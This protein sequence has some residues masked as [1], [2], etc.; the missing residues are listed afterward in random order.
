MWA[1]KFCYCGD[2]YGLLV[3]A[4]CLLAPFF[5]CKIALSVNKTTLFRFIPRRCRFRRLIPFYAWIMS[6]IVSHHEQFILGWPNFLVHFP[7]LVYQTENHCR[8]KGYTL[9]QNVGQITRLNNIYINTRIKDFNVQ[10]H[11]SAKLSTE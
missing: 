7:Q 10:A 1:P 4:L 3:F 8:I 6:G 2:V 5:F 9:V 11:N